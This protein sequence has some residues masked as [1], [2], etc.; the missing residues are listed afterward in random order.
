MAAKAQ[1]VQPWARLVQTSSSPAGKH[2]GAFKDDCCVED[3]E[4]VSPVCISAVREPV[5]ETI[6]DTPT[7]IRKFLRSKET[8]VLKAWFRNF[9]RNQ[10]GRIDFDEFKGGM[11]A[12]RF[13]G[14]I[15]GLWA[16]LDPESMGDVCFDIIEREE[17]RLWI[18]FKKF[19][20]ERF[21]GPRDLIR[22]FKRAAL[23]TAN[24]A[25]CA[26]E[27]TMTDVEFVEG[28]RAF[29]WNEG[30][31][32][33]LF[34]AL[35][36]ESELCLSA[37]DFKWLDLEVRR[38]KQKEAAKKRALRIAE[39]KSRS[40]QLC[41]VA[42][43]NFKAFLRRHFGPIFRAWRSALDSDGSMSL[44]R[45][46][47]FKICRS[48]NWR[49]DV[50][51]LW[52]SLDHDGSGVTT[53]EELDPHCAQ[54]LG[55]FKIWASDHFG[56]KPS[57][58]LWQA[59]DRQR[60]RKLSYSQ[61]TQE[62]EVRGFTRKTKTIAMWLD[63]QDK[64]YLQEE[65]LCIFDTWRPP[66]WLCGMPNPQAAKDFTK[67]LLQR[68]GHI[69]RAWRSALDK[70]NS[71][72]CNWHEF[73]DAAKHVR[74]VGDVAGAWLTLDQDLSGFI[75]LKEID[76]SAHESLVEFKRWA[77]DEFG[78]VRSAFKVLDAD[79]SN[80]LTYFE[81]RKACLMY[82]FHGDLKT[83]FDSL[84]QNCEGKLH[85][86]ELMFLDDWDSDT[87]VNAGF[88]EGRELEVS[89]PETESSQAQPIDMLDHRTTAPGPGAYNV[90]SGFGAMPCMPT[91][92]HHGAFTFASSRRPLDP[93]TKT[94]GPTNYHV[95]MKPTTAKK[96][97]WSFGSA[98]RW[99]G[100]EAKEREPVRLTTLTARRGSPGP[101]AYELKTTFEGPTFMMRPRR[102]L[103]VHPSQSA[104]RTPDISPRVRLPPRAQSVASA[105]I[106]P[107]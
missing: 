56:P 39:Q 95:S 12:L 6:E 107:T 52:K 81:F 54:H 20:A 98:S 73:R 16:D 86:K 2:D 64:K 67:H 91:A 97:S 61:F 27:E 62:C 100:V 48:L 9:D 74:Y 105:R 44:Q 71:N 99:G 68:Y 75:T 28:S 106:V 14:D 89:Q 1:E 22:Q 15:E 65:D 83:L 7:V 34:A 50:R 18:A 82:G 11:Q 77:D 101:G 84:D 17:A 78:G 25:T 76:V 58:G 3:A 35:D 21:Q 103:V 43:N 66:E 38:F 102:G 30:F 51:A 88:D 87:P 45:A 24:P 4:D 19:C 33:V 23:P 32:S 72:M 60:R 59:F 46:D 49:G 10:N 55:F 47:L 53:L 40:K 90:L 80:E 92:R 41:I 29:G 37:R 26:S 94:V 5:Q 69:L 8:P 36:T 85:F 13:P 70:D 79:A 31:E 57:A 96:P 63:W 42:L 104:T 93:L